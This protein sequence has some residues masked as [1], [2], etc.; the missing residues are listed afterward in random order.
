MSW[1]MAVDSSSRSRRAR[2]RIAFRSSGGIRRLFT[3][4]TSVRLQ[5][6][7]RLPVLVLTDLTCELV[8]EREPLRAGRLLPAAERDDQGGGRHEGDAEPLEELEEPPIVA[9]DQG[10]SAGPGQPHDGRL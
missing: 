3:V 1:R 2:Y 7:P 9:D 4:S 5:G 10:R 6:S 8:Q